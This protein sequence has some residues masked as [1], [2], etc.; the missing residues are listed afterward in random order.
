ML[1]RVGVRLTPILGIV[2]VFLVACA[3][4]LPQQGSPGAEIEPSR[5]GPKRL[6]TA[7]MAE[8]LALYRPLIP[9]G[10]TIQTADLADT[11]LNMG[12][13]TYDHRGILQAKMAEAVPTA[14]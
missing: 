1:H 11:I 6:V 7:V 4:P 3:T 10:S 2:S 5:T 13:S 8:P 9:G 14:E 12:L